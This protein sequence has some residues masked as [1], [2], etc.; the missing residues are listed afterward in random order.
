MPLVSPNRQRRDLLARTAQV[1]GLAALMVL[2]CRSAP[3]AAKAAKSEVMYQDHRHD[4][5][6]CDQCKFFAPDRS[7]S[8][9]G[10]CSMVDGSVS[11][12]GWCTFF[13]TK[14]LI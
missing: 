2:T 12:D 13:S 9:V 7:N 1:A 3:V 8:G 6:S 11:R 5:K 4:G 14:T 10:S